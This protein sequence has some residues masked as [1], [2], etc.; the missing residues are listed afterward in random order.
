MER[1]R[2]RGWRGEGLDLIGCYDCVGRRFLLHTNNSVCRLVMN[3][4]MSRSLR[5]VRTFTS[6]H[7]PLMER[8]RRRGEGTETVNSRAANHRRQG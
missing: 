7:L 3:R 6:I 5:S 4:Q 2:E 1:R 8:R